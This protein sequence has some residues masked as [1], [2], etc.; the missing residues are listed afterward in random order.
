MFFPCILLLNII[1]EKIW[2]FHFNF[3]L[4]KKYLTLNFK[5]EQ[6]MTSLCSCSFYCSMLH[7]IQY[8]RSFFCLP[9]CCRI[10]KRASRNFQT[11]VWA[12]ILHMRSKI[13]INPYVYIFSIIFFIKTNILTICDGSMACHKGPTR[14]INPAS[15]TANTRPL[16]ILGTERLSTQKK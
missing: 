14:G 15:G 2:Y 9:W 12:F 16:K 4:D 3:K 10:Y 6:L 8:G 11:F 7:I 13:A 5:G 1:N